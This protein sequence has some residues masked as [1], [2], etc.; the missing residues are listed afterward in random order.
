M[1]R[2][3]SLLMLAAGAPFA[4]GLFAWARPAAPVAMTPPPAK[5]SLAF[6]QYAVNLGPVRPSPYVGAHFDF[7]NRSDKPVRI[8]KLTPSCGCVV[9]K[10]LDQRREYGPGQFGSIQASVATANESAGPH[11]YTI[12]VAYDDGQPREQVIRLS[13]ELPE[14]TVSIEPREVYFYQ[15]NGEPA[16]R[17]VHVVD[18][19]PQPL[20]I[21]SIQMALGQDPCPDTLAVATLEPVE[22]DEHRHARFPIRIEVAGDVPPTRIVAHVIIQTNDPQFSVLKVPVAIQGPTPAVTPASATLPAAVHEEP[23]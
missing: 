1:D 5:P 19:R 4:A 23:H 16:S 15:L 9:T 12:R 22:F 2:V 10:A 20:E 21:R 8:T 18:H 13:M 17:V 11:D 6:H 14:P 3:R 7:V